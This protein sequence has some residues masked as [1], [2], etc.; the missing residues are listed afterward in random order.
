[1]KFISN[2]P[3]EIILYILNYLNL[4]DN[5]KLIKLSTQFKTLIM[6]KLNNLIGKNSEID[7]EFSKELSKYTDN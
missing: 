3:N 6:F 1:M 4:I 5:I 2:L 7:K